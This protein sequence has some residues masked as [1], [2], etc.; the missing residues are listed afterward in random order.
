METKSAHP[1]RTQVKVFVLEEFLGPSWRQE[2]PRGLK[3]QFWWMLIRFFLKI[4]EGSWANL[5][6]IW[7]AFWECC[8]FASQK[9]VFHRSL[10]FAIRRS[11]WSQLGPCCTGFQARWRLHWRFFIYFYVF[12]MCFFI[13]FLMLLMC[14]YMFFICFYMFSYDNFGTM[15]G[16]SG[17]R[18]GLW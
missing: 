13:C 5:G 17:P 4:L 11:F 16:S 18:M 2:G 12:F 15:W 3:S 10:L 8:V 6:K 1:S 7:E 9:N 14:F